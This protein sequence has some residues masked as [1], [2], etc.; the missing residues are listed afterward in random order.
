MCCWL[1][2]CCRAPPALSPCS[3]HR[4]LSVPRLTDKPGQCHGRLC[5]LHLGHTHRNTGACIHT[6]T[7]THSCQAGGSSEAASELGGTW[8][9]SGKNW[10]FRNPFA[11]S[12]FL[13]L[14]ALCIQPLP[15][16][17]SMFLASDFPVS[18]AMSPALTELFL[19]S[20]SVKQILLL[21]HL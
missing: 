15:P 19:I 17:S 1:E 7:H 4:A 5:Y 3:Q 18:K 10:A 8:R 13:Q 14:A 6:H 12:L 20:P 16:G 9:L 2:E 21:G 11:F